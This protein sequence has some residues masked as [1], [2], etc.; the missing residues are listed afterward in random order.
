MS[1]PDPWELILAPK[2]DEW[3]GANERSAGSAAAT[4]R[5]DRTANEVESERRAT[6]ADPASLGRERR[7]ESMQG[8]G[9]EA[10]THCPAQPPQARAPATLPLP[11][12]RLIA[13]RPAAEVGFARE[14]R[15]Y[16]NVYDIYMCIQA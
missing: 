14:I 7:E 9:A 13:D 16:W 10:E 12:C 15:Q 8:A 1:S 6:R 11:V 4:A 3:A 5:G 2:G